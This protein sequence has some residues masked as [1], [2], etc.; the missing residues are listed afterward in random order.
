VSKPD[1]DSFLVGPTAGLTLSIPVYRQLGIVGGAD[2][3]THTVPH[4]MERRAD[5]ITGFIGLE[6]S[7]DIAPIVPFVSAGGSFQHAWRQDRNATKDTFSGFIGLGIK[8]TLADHLLLGI[9]VRYLS[10]GLTADQF[11]AF[12]IFTIQVGWTTRH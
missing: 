5:T 3:S 8:T 1:G 11:P 7:L 10:A 4:H 9:S 6:V 2:F 12:S